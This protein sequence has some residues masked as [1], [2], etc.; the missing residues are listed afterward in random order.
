MDRKLRDRDFGR[1]RGREGGLCYWKAARH[2]PF[3]NITFLL[4]F[5][6]YPIQLLLLCYSFSLLTSAGKPI[7]S[8]DQH[9]PM[10]CQLLGSAIVSFIALSEDNVAIPWGNTGT[11]SPC[12]IFV[13][14]WKV[15]NVGASTAAIVSS[16]HLYSIHSIQAMWVDLAILVLYFCK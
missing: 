11:F 4:K 9:F 12:G 16:K 13:S 10:V 2:P 3:R 1:R 5:L 15:L 7:I 14:S 6:L 8:S